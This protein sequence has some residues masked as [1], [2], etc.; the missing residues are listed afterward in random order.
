MNSQK[1]ILYISIMLLVP[2]IGGYFISKVF[3]NSSESLMISAT[4]SLYINV[5]LFFLG[6]I[7]EGIKY[8]RGKYKETQKVFWLEWI[9]TT[10]SLWIIGI[11]LIGIVQAFVRLR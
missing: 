6:F 1:A 11:I 3:M 8:L 4:G 5:Q 7:V 10:F 9:E 2:F